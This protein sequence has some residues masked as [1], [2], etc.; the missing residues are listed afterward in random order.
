ML[1]NEQGKKTEQKKNKIKLLASGKLE[2]N[3]IWKFWEWETK[4]NI[5]RK[6]AR[7]N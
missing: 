3:A 4:Q 6:R 2:W 1:H 5:Q 7:E